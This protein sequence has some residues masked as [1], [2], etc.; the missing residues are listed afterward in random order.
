MWLRKGKRYAETDEYGSTL[1]VGPI[2]RL[3][4]RNCRAVRKS[5]PQLLA[6]VLRLSSVRHGR[7]GSMAHQARPLIINAVGAW[8]PFCTTLLGLAVGF[9]ER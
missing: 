4:E 9:E 1:N 3:I 6:Q 5:A 2:N 8:N 7:C